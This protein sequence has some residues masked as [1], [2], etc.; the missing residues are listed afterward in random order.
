MNCRAGLSQ[1]AL[2]D[3]YVRPNLTWTVIKNVPIR[4]SFS[5]EYGS[6][7][8]GQL[9]TSYGKK[10]SYYNAGLSVSYSPLSLPDD[11]LGLQ[12]HGPDFPT[13]STGEYAQNVISLNLVYALP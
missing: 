6:Q 2:E 7:R 11:Q 8:G 9:S 1:N 4:T 10:F 5:Y 3:Y 13:T 12:P